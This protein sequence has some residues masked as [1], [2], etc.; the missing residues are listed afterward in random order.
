MQQD[1]FFEIYNLWLYD[2][3]RAWESHCLVRV[4]T[5]LSKADGSLFNVHI[6]VPKLIYAKIL[7]S[8]H[9]AEIETW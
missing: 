2:F 5:K 1:S 8:L 9:C 6:T 3:W 7:K 4:N